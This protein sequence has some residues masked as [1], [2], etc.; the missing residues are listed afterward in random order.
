[1]ADYVLSD[2]NNKF[3]GKARNFQSGLMNFINMIAEGQLI[4]RGKVLVV[5]ITENYRGD[6]IF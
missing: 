1:M 4:I 5:V 2:R 6:M 3:R